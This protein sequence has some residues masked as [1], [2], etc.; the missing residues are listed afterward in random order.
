MALTAPASVPQTVGAPKTQGIARATIAIQKANPGM[1]FKDAY[2]A[3]EKQRQQLDLIA[4]TEQELIPPIPPHSVL[5]PEVAAAITHER[6]TSIA[7]GTIDAKAEQAR[8]TRRRPIRPTLPPPWPL[9]LPLP[10]PEPSSQLQLPLPLPLELAG[11]ASSAPELTATPVVGD[12][13]TPVTSIPSEVIPPTV[14]AP[15]VPAKRKPG[16]PRKNTAAPATP[17]QTAPNDAETQAAKVK[18]TTDDAVARIAEI[19]RG[20]EAALK[21]VTDFSEGVPI[22][23]KAADDIV[24]I[25]EAAVPVLGRARCLQAR[26]KSP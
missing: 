14:E 17:G 24:S 13:K 21:S 26:R 18:A 22:A 3:A 6:A 10:L 16:R 11:A 2:A 9:Q 8:T 20:R 4:Q 12:A 23:T 5:D 15:P 7:K 1:S 25:M 19:I